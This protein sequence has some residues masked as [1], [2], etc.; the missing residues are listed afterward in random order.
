MPV[1]GIFLSFCV[2][3]P[4]CAS[5]VGIQS[6]MQLKQEVLDLLVLL[7]LGSSNKL[8][9]DWQA[10]VYSRN[11]HAMRNP[12]TPESFEHRGAPWY[13]EQLRAL[14]RASMPETQSCPGT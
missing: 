2:A 5:P 6:E 9:L 7:G 8:Q 11:S 3:D 1:A 10:A 12:S 4:V 14:V 13:P